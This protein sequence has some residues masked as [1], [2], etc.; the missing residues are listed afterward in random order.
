VTSELEHTSS[1]SA[2]ESDGVTLAEVYAQNAQDEIHLTD[3]GDGRR[4][5]LLYRHLAKYVADTGEW[6]VRDGEH[7]RVDE[8]KL[9]VFSLTAGV[10][11][12]IR[13]EAL[14]NPDPDVRDAMLAYAAKTEGEQKRHRIINSALENKSELVI[15]EDDLDHDLDIIAT[16]HGVV[17]LLTGEWRPTRVDDFCTAHTS[18]TY[19]PDATSPLLDQYLDTFVP[20]PVDQ[21]VLFAVLGTILR[22]GNATRIFPIFLGG[23]TSGKSQLISALDN[24]LGDYVCSINASVF[25]G[26][27]DDKPRPDIVRA[28]NKR[29][30]Y[31]VEASKVWELHADHIKKIT[32]GDKLPYR[33]LYSQDQEKLPRFSLLIVTN[34]MPRIKGA[35]AP[36]RRRMITFRFDQTLP[37]EQEDT[38]IKKK[39]ITDER[40]LQALLARIVTGARSPLMRDGLK[41]T[42][43]PRKYASDTLDSFNQLDHVSE[44]LEWLSDREILTPADMSVTP[45]SHCARANELHEWYVTWINK[46]GNKQ[47]KQEAL[48]MK[49]F[50]NALRERGWES[51][52]SG[53][54]RWLNV[55]LM[56]SPSAWTAW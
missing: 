7:W 39:F 20:D 45:V 50:G 25:R 32:G 55:K 37:P 23:T 12:Q 38:S 18:V 13:E 36:L 2:E 44:F 52:L 26:N 40:C 34:A 42:L 33:N 49:E 43:L 6:V 24:L 15:Q 16:P 54:T 35:D 29:I 28:M 17:N 21:E 14:F 53:G 8:K 46:H 31:A 27:Q 5:A 19:D 4:F 10:T 47:D 1:D 11:R 51:K 30:A 48:N 22:G 56:I 41:W 3:R 9:D